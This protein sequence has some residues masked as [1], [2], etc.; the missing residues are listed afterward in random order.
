MK[1]AL[2]GAGLLAASLL[3]GACSRTPLDPNVAG[4]R[5]LPGHVE[6]FSEPSFRAGRRCWVYL[7]PSYAWS[8]DR[9]P[10]LYA[11][12]GESVFDDGGEMHVNRVCEDMIRSGEIRPIIVVAIE[13]PFPGAFS[14][15]FWELA[16]W[17]DNYFHD[18]GGGDVFLRA[19]R[20]TLKPAIDRHFRT[21]P[22]PANTAIAGV[23]LGGNFAAYAGI[24][25]GGTFGNVAAFS[26]TYGL[27]NYYIEHVTDS[28]GRANG[29]RIRRYYQDSGTVHDN[30]I[31]GM[32]QVLTRY[33]FRLGVN[34][35]SVTVPEA[36]HAYGAWTRRYPDMLRFLFG[37]E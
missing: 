22:D 31:D 11:T 8:G 5:A 25:Y 30:Y 7:P 32:D 19:I 21:L 17:Y 18:G 4:W 27:R 23:S 29:F 26:P 34:Y 13:N 15:R 12:D 10:V 2:L 37:H 1:P 6:R 3:A 9:Y 20:D 28:V 24:M 16:P 35:L 14:P 33:G 36:K